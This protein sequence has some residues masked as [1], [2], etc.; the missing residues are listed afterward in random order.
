MCALDKL[1]LASAAKAV[2]PAVPETVEV[3]EKTLSQLNETS[4]VE[5]RL[6]WSPGNKGAPVRL[7]LRDPVACDSSR[8]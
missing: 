3:D 6:H 7:G 2:G 1:T 8:D 5:P 4:I